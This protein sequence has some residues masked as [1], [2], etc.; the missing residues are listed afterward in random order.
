MKVS[1]RCVR[2]CKHVSV[3]HKI[4]YY[5]ELAQVMA[6]AIQREAE[7]EEACNKNP[8]AVK[9]EDLELHDDKEADMETA[10]TRPYYKPVSGI[11]YL[12]TLLHSQNSL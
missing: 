11:L 10:Y 3:H 5:G 2:V 8:D 1:R 12:C 4:A 7:L 9:A 6:A